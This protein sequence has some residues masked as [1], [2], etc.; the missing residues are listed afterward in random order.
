MT[1]R[2]RRSFL[3][4]LAL[5]AAGCNGDP[6]PEPGP[7]AEPVERA[8]G[9][10]WTVERFEVVEDWVA[11]DDLAGVDWEAEGSAGEDWG[12]ALAE[13]LA[14]RTMTGRNFDRV[15][16]LDGFA[17]E[18]GHGLLDLAFGWLLSQPMISSMIA[19]ATTPAQ[20]AD[21]VAAASAWRLDAA[22]LD[23]VADILADA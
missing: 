1:R 7:P 2:D 14:R 13:G 12:L 11:S 17:R 16:A 4:A 5:L 18:Q 10:L 3:L 22:Q 21:N 6:E 20:V 19:G 15:E 23:A 9:P 8:V